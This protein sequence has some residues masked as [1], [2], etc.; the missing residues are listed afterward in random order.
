MDGLRCV[1][2]KIHW[3]GKSLPSDW[4]ASISC[5]SGDHSWHTFAFRHLVLH[6][7]KVRFANLQKKKTNKSFWLGWSRVHMHDSKQVLQLGPGTS[8]WRSWNR[9]S[10]CL[11]CRENCQTKAVWHSIPL[12]Y[13]GDQHILFLPS[14]GACAKPHLFLSLGSSAKSLEIYLG[15]QDLPNFIVFS[16]TLWHYSAEKVFTT[17]TCWWFEP[18]LCLEQSVK[19]SPGCAVYFSNFKRSQTTPTHSA[20]LG[21]NQVPLCLPR[22]VWFNCGTIGE[23]REIYKNIVNVS[24][25]RETEVLWPRPSKDLPSLPHCD[26]FA[27]K[28]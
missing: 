26:P 6:H 4:Q 23:P 3:E 25:F 10:T 12:E 22:L 17:R 8:W 5:G 11:T 24:Y 20:L 21:C 13:K 14:E 16:R 1:R 2:I 18:L 19:H 9:F 28:A 15:R 7:L 27:T